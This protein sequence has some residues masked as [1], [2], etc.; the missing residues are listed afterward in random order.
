MPGDAG[1]T[2]PQATPSA[3]AVDPSMT[4]LE[5][6][7]ARNEKLLRQIT[8]LLQEVKDNATAQVA[9]GVGVPSD[10]IDD[11]SDSAKKDPAADM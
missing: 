3:A 4:T 6:L 11:G 7:R 8:K 9:P 5:D 2:A 10:D 1:S